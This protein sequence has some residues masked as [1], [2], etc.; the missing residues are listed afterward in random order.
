MSLIYLRESL[1][2]EFLKHSV[3]EK[4]QNMIHDICDSIEDYYDWYQDSLF[5]WLYTLT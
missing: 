1:K 4:N 3:C 5:L 2:L